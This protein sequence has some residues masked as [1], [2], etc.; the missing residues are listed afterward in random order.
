MLQSHPLCAK[1][2]LRR[3]RSQ[4]HHIDRG[5]RRATSV[6]AGLRFISLA[7]A[8]WLPAPLHAQSTNI[9]GVMGVT[10]QLVDRGMA[11]SPA[12]PILQG[13]VSLTSAGGWSFGLSGGAEV[14]SPGRIEEAS[15]QA[16]RYWSLSSDWQ[17]QTSLLY[18]SYPGNARSRVFDRTEAGV[19]WIYRDILTFD[20]SAIRVAGAKDHQTGGSADL[21]FHWP[22]PWQLSLSAGAGVAQSLIAPYSSGHA[23]L[24]SYGQAGLMWNNGSWRVELD[25]ITTSAGTPRHSGSLSPAPWV[26]TMSRSF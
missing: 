22:L 15:A 5:I 19:N 16:S 26:A 14:R 8:A 18:Y 21:D 3:Y 20:L 24:Y 9:S 17:M 11:I 2:S 4:L 6:H 13:A 12:T 7:I 23:N 25:R 10:S 1:V